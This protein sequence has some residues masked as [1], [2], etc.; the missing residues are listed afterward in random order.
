MLDG[1]FNVRPYVSTDLAQIRQI[2]TASEADLSAVAPDGFFDDL[3]NI[4]VA[5]R[6]GLFLVCER[7]REVAGFGGLFPTG[8]IVRMRVASKYRRKGIA[9]LVLN[10]LVE[11]ARTLGMRRVYLHTLEEQRPA[12]ALYEKFGFVES[13]RGE[14]HGNKVIAYELDL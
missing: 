6:S 2:H 7:E 3:D 9:T 1:R 8:E 14:I 11:G 5:Y 4:P 12:H 10:G 13:G